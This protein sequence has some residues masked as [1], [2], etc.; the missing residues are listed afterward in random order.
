MATTT[1]ILPALAQLIKDT[2]PGTST[3]QIEG[4]TILRI[5]TPRKGYNLYHDHEF[6][7]GTITLMSHDPIDQ[8]VLDLNDPN[9]LPTLTHTLQTLENQ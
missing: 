9:S 3:T 5:R 1:D 4:S 8:L 7:G 6:D 2:I